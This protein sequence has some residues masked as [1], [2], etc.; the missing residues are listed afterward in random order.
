M[1]SKSSLSLSSLSLS[2]SSGGAH[3]TY[4]LPHLPLLVPF[5]YSAGQGS[6]TA[7][8]RGNKCPHIPSPA[9]LPLHDRGYQSNTSGLEAPRWLSDRHYGLVRSVGTGEEDHNNASSSDDSHRRRL[10]AAY[11][12]ELSPSL[13][14]SCFVSRG[15]RCCP[16][17][18]CRTSRVRENRDV[19]AF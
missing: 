19:Q 6:I 3:G 9:G 11:W 5:H 17:A 10:P 14:L 2:V 8:V 1:G 13:A 16:S 15:V 12:S 4:V 18:Q 7:N